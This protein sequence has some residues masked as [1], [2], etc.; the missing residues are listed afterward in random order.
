MR[1][2]TCNVFWIIL[3]KDVRHVTAAFSR[4]VSCY[5]RVDCANLL[6]KGGEKVDQ[7]KIGNFLKG[8]RKGKGITQENLAEILHVSGRTVSRGETG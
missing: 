8:L 6:M 1:K 5:G 3:D 4:F 2:R 7:K